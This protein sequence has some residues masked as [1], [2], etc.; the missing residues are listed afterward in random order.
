MQPAVSLRDWQ[1]GMQAAVTVDDRG[2]L[3]HVVG[4]ARGNAA[5]RIGV[6]VEAYPLRLLDVLRQDYRGLR[7]ALGEARFERLARAYIA[8]QPSDT[9]SIRWFGRHF[10][11]FLRRRRTRPAW[12]AELAAFE[13]AQGE[14]FDAADAPR[15]QPADLA[16][17]ALERWPELRLR[18]HPAQ[19]RLHLRWNA[20]ALWQAAIGQAKDDA[21]RP[22]RAAPRHWLL[23]R[24]GFDVRWRSLD[25]AEAAALSAAAADASLADIGA[26]LLRAGVPGDTAPNHLAALLQTWLADGLIT[27]LRN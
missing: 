23:W 25:A 27:E 2:I 3:A 17:L 7:V 18:L 4:D 9:P 21:T 11:T 16:G 20:P 19:R 12:A 10:A 1:R 5:T 15:A 8:A 24:H 14:V 26:A 22:Q 6:Y 13:W